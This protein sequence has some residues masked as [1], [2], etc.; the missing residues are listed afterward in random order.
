M[1]KPVFCSRISFLV[2]LYLTAVG[3]QRVSDQRG[4]APASG[5]AGEQSVHLLVLQGPAG[6]TLA[7]APVFIEE[8]G[9]FAF[10]LD[11][12]A[13]QSVID[14]ELAEQLHL[15][16][17]GKAL[18]VTGVAATAEASQVRVNNWR[19]G[20]VKL[21]GRTL[22][23]LALS[24]PNRR[25]KLRGLLGSDVLSQFGSV[26]VDYSQQRLLLRARP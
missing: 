9:P 22:I 17:A 5:E 18:E 10:A 19:V 15:P 23:S 6:S 21:R 12:G 26:L 11:T 25:L 13:S 14:E 16:Q 7:L 2:L 24:E 8:Q 20:E 4:A 1:K 3:C